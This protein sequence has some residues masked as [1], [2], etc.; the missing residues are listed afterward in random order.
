MALTGP[1]IQAALEASRGAGPFPLLGLTY[2]QIA[3]AVGTAMQGWALAQPQNLALTGS[4]LGPAGSGIILAPTTRL[5]VPPD[6]VTVQAGLAAVGIVGPTS[7]SVS[8]AIAVGLSTVFG[9]LG[10]YTGT[11]TVGAGPDVSKI[12]VANPATLAALMVPIFAGMV[13]PGPVSAQLATGLSNGIAALL[14]LGTGVGVVT[15][16]PG[17]PVPVPPAIPGL[18]FSVV[19]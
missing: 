11:A 12:V 19:V 13:G 16:G 14:L 17:A 5:V 15:P 2:S 18:T 4:T 9:T 10:Q 7:T 1:A 6:P 8:T 3:L